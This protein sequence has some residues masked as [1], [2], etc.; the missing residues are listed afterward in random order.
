MLSRRKLLGLGVGALSFPIL[1]L[2]GNWAGGNQYNKLFKHNTQYINELF[3][4]CGHE[5]IN[6]AL[7][8]IGEM[9]KIIKPSI[10][11]DIFKRTGLS[12]KQ[13][14]EYGWR[15]MSSFSVSQKQ[16]WDMRWDIFNL[17]M[18]KCMNYLCKK[19]ER[20]KTIIRLDFFGCLA[21]HSSYYEYSGGPDIKGYCHRIYFDYY[22]KLI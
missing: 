9:C 13:G 21:N 8:S 4:N 12:V 20:A 17:N 10:E 5:N 6:I 11:K 22:L 15:L 7:Q 3:R 1:G 2:G 16:A 18:Y 14:E 19:I